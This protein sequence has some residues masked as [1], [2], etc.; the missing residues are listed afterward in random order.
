MRRIEDYLDK[1]R[2]YVRAL[3]HPQIKIAVLE[4][5]LVPHLR[6]A[7]RPARG[8]QPA[9]LYEKL[10][11]EL[12]M[13]LP[14]AADAQ[15]DRRPEWRAFIYHDHVSWF[16]GSGYVVEKLFRDHYAPKHL[17]STSGTF[18]DIPNRSDLLRRRSRR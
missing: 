4:W 11:P 2:D 18:R 1:L 10:S 8:R 6:L 9:S 7:G 3:A 12:A 17:A 15:H 16:P 13:T 14:G 5:R